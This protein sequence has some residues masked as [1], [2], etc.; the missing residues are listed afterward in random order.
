MAKGRH[1]NGEKSKARNLKAKQLA[2]GPMDLPFLML[3]LMLLAI[4]LIML[5]SSSYAYGASLSKYNNDPYYFIKSQ[6]FYAAI[7]LVLMYIISRI[8]YQFW[9]ALSIP[10]LLVAIITLV[11]VLIPGVG[12]TL[13]GAT[14]WLHLFLVA[15]PT[16]QPSEIAKL[17][18]ILFFSASLSKR[19]TGLHEFKTTL[20]QPWEGIRHWLDKVGLLELLPYL[21]ILLLVAL[22]MLLEPHMSGT[23]L[24][25][26]AGASIMF[27]AGTRWYWYIIAL[28][29]GGGMLIY[30]MTQTEYMAT[31]IETWLDPWDAAASSDSAYQIT[32][33]LIAIGSGG[34]LGKGLGQSV[35]KYMYLPEP[36]NDFIF[37]IVAEE[38]GFVGCLI[39]LALFALLIIRG[40]W[41]SLHARDRFGSLLVVGITTLLAT[42]V[43]LNIA[44]VTG[45]I[46]T[47]G[48]SLPFFSYGGTALIIQ[49]CE[50]GIVLSVS[51][52]IPAPK[53]ATQKKTSSTETAAGAV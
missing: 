6:A 13:G 16:Y 42:Q 4:G 14:R 8:D 51:R 25:L 43:F 7:G 15:G 26:A 18:I 39:I 24:I 2:H 41:L 44:V 20:K 52:Q 40:Y 30:I 17:G 9:R 11:L 29:A 21:F 1:E 46:P 49:L 22:L 53:P 3:V 32:Q 33:S 5:F 23:I 34:L 35:Q 47:T 50:M 28:G 36:Y 37:A 38:L 45:L 10:V 12:V 31:R 19:K 27:A 48:I